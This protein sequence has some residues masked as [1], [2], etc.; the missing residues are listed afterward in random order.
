[1]SSAPLRVLFAASEFA[2]LA[3]TGG[4]AD[5]AA[6][7][8]AAL[9]ELGVDVRVLLPAYREVLAGLGN[10]KR[11]ARL[12]AIGSF[13]AAEILEAEGPRQQ[14]LLALVCP[15]LFERD[16]GP[17]VDSA[18]AD[19][20][21]NALRFGLLSHAAAVLATPASPYDWR[22]DVLHCNDWQTAL[23]PAFHF[24]RR[25]LRAPCLMTIHNL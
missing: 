23:A 25:S 11:V 17:Y 9:G 16:G 14:R 12:P 22:C 4:L 24:W 20:P 18:G 1:M 10:A 13:P 3:K 21:D 8:T 2:P 19:W 15:A 5:V 7:L 6:A